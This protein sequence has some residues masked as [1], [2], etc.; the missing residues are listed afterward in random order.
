[1]TR[2][3]RI[4]VTFTGILITLGIASAVLDRRASV[5]ASTGQAP[6][7]EVDPM[8]PKPLPNHWVMGNTIGVSVDA[9]DHVW[10]IHRAGSLEAKEVYAVTNPPGAECCL[11]A[12][13]V[14]EFD[15]AGNLIGHWGGQDGPGYEWPASNHGITVDYKGN[16]WI[17]GNGR[18][19]AATGPEEA[20]GAPPGAAAAAAQTKQ[21]Q[22]KQ[23][24]GGPPHYHDSMVLKF[25]QEGKF[26]MA[27]GKPNGSEGSNDVENLGLP[28]KT[29]I[30]PKTN[31]LYVADGYGNKRVIVYDADT[32]KYK[33]HWGAYG[34]KPDDTNPGPYKP[35]APVDQQFRSPVHCSELSHDGLLYV[36]DRLNDRIQ[37]FKPDGT[38]VKEVFI[39]KNTLG[40]GSVWDIAFSKD[41][42]QTYMYL[43][44]GANEKVYVMQRETLEI[45][46]SFG[47]GGRQPGQFYAVHS[48]ASDSK[49]NIYTTET[50]RGQR[51]QKFVYKGLA[52][53]SKKDQGVVW[54]K[55]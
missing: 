1:M 47:D 13:P 15:Q 11:P 32:G 34:H 18:T 25:T 38:F 39:A 53:I 21:K 40:D 3:L 45:L 23:A 44:D 43:A 41:P 22:A 17:A 6:R 51:V 37:V 50:Y 55:K 42:K 12:P 26:L 49:G 28:A 5:E 10:I 8:W 2:N 52:A 24:P 31:E 36:C 54:P 9:Q 4:G 30:D 20:G 46:T 14:L 29:F 27:I 7:F 16:V 19:R 33:R 35:D 48:I